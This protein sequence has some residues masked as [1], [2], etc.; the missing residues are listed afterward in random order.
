MARAGPFGPQAPVPPGDGGGFFAVSCVNGADCWAVGAVLGV[1]GNGN[2]ASGTLIEN[3]NGASWSI[4]PSPTPSGPGVQGAV[5]QGVTCMSAT[6]CVAVGFSTDD[7]GANLQAVIEQWDGSTW[8]L[9]PGAD[10]GQAFDQLSGVTC[11]S[12]PLIAGLSGTPGPFGWISNFLPIFP[13]A[14]GDQGLIEHWDE[15]RR[16]R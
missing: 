14:V 11:V 16:G 2:R 6:D 8:T 4:V 10:T 7:T 15:G 12:G 3:W 9:V 5:L 1:S 13:G